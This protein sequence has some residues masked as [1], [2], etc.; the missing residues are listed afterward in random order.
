MTTRKSFFIAL[1]L[2]L[3]PTICF[4]SSGGSSGKSLSTLSDS[5]KE[6]IVA[7]A[8]VLV[9][10]SYVAGIGFALAG[11]VQFKAHKDNPAQVP[12]SKAIVYL[13]VAACLLFLPNILD[14]AGQ[15][16]FGGDAQEGLKKK[17]STSSS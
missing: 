9:I 2:F 7:V 1:L 15:T 12:L 14:T 11:I 3:V 10:V 13:I 17:F 5:L 16:I 6:Q 4:A 8:N